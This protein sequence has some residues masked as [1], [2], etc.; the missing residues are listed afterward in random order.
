MPIGKYDKF[1]SGK[2]GSA[3]KAK[4]AMAKQYG[5]EEGEKVFY[6]TKNRNKKRGSTK[7]SSKRGR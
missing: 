1:F 4:T 5:S 6:A 3:A 2:P 7:S